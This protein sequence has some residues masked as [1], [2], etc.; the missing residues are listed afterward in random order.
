MTNVDLKLKGG[1]VHLPGGPAEV[2][3]GVTGGRIVAIGEVGDAGE[4]IDCAITSRKAPFS[5]SAPATATSKR[6]H[7]AI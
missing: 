7:R 5:S 2:E 4:T 3:I 1:R 6:C